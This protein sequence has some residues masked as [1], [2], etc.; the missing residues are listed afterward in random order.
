[1]VVLGIYRPPHGIGLNYYQL[2]EDELNEI[3]SW[4]SSQCQTIIIMSDLNKLKAN[5]RKGKLLT[6][7]EEVMRSHA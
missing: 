5:E 2:L 7:M 6:D 1:M 3:I 4:A